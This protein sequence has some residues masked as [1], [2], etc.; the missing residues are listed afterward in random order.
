MPR[1]K[2]MIQATTFKDF[3]GLLNTISYNWKKE[4]IQSVSKK[5]LKGDMI[6]SS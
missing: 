5:N 2:T 6:I 3:T 1:Q 4:V